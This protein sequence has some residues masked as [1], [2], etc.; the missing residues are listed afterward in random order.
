MVAVDSPAAVPVPVCSTASPFV[1]QVIDTETSVELSESGS[2]P[3]LGYT[4]GYAPPE[5]V[6]DDGVVN[7]TTDVYA[8]GKVLE[9]YVSAS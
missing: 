7:A 8:L 1:L 9:K 2:A 6:G 4:E 5:A 3:C